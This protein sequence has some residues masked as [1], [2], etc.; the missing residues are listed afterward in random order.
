MEQSRL[1]RNN[2]VAGNSPISS[3]ARPRIEF[4]GAG[5]K[6]MQE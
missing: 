4:A 2:D 1:A 6:L 5:P 3:S